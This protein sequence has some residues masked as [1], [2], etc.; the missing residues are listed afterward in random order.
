MYPHN[1]IQLIL[2]MSRIPFKIPESTK[3]N[4]V[5]PT[6]LNIRVRSESNSSLRWQLQV[7]RFSVEYK[8]QIVPSNELC[9]FISKRWV[10]LAGAQHAVNSHFN[11][12]KK[13]WVKEAGCFFEILIF[14]FFIVVYVFIIILKCGK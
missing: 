3:T 5:L 4:L 12:A 8:F 9:I 10:G 1:N 14:W 2:F 6:K 7:T 11:T 13:S